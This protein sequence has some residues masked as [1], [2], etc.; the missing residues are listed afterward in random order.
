VSSRVNHVSVNARDLEQ[1]AE[2]YV[3]L[4]GADRIPS[5]NFDLPVLWLAFGRTELHLFEKDVE[6]PSHHH[7]GITVDDLEPVY[8]AAKRRGAF[9][10]EAFGNHLVELPG[11]VVQLYVRDP[12]G[13]LVEFDQRGVDRLPEDMRAELKGV[14][15]INPQTDANLRGRLFV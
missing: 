1:S 10:R 2:F 5:P 4:L 12:A 6:P 14:W 13:N 8:R 15:E 9:D 11:D 3:E 7:V